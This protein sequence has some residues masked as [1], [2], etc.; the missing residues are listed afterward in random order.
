MMRHGRFTFRAALSA[1]ALLS[2]TLGASGCRTALTSPAVVAPFFDGAGDLQASASTGT[3]AM[4]FS[5]AWSPVD[6]FGVVATGAYIPHYSEVSSTYHD[7]IT[8]MAGWYLGG[9]DL[10]LELLAG[11]GRGRIG[12]YWSATGIT[13]LFGPPVAEDSIVS[14][15]RGSYTRY[16][17]Q[18]DIGQTR[19]AGT[20]DRAPRLDIGL[21]LGISWIDFDRLERIDLATESHPSGIGTIPLPRRDALFIDPTLI[22]RGGQWPLD[23][24]L[25]L[26]TAH[27]WRE[28]DFSWRAFHIALGARLHVLPGARQ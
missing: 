24:E 18:I 2:A 22:L 8:T 21:C 17:A 19:R 7:F 20:T 9:Q 4:Q 15:M 25:Q 3:N 10:R 1:A 11:L 12:E 6:H 13:V 23:L 14:V 16:A 27:T 28:V 26:G 5:A